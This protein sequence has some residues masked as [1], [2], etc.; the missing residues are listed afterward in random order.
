MGIN[1]LSYVDYVDNPDS[2]RNFSSFVLHVCG[3]PISWVSKVQYSASLSNSEAEWVAALE[4]V[5]EVTF[6]LQLL[7]EKNHKNVSLF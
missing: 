4:A 5:K 6:V 7:H 2:R 3:V 1:L